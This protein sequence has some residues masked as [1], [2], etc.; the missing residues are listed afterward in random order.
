MLISYIQSGLIEQNARL[1]RLTEV[2]QYNEH[3]LLRAA[4][5]S[6]E[7]DRISEAI[8]LFNLAGDYPTVVSCL[9]IALGNIL[10]NSGPDEKAHSI[11]RTAKEILHHYERTNKVVGRNY[12]AASNL[13][14]IREAME[15]KEN[16]DLEIALGLLE[17]TNLV[18]LAEDTM[19]IAKKVEE[20]KDLHES[21]QRNLPVYL[22]LTMRTL[23]E[24]YH[25]VKNS[26]V[27]DATKQKVCISWFFDRRKC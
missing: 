25:K 7:N 16:G 18:P 3:I 5:R 12:D 19:K 20:F 4:R 10:A 17:N 24:V 8:K 2:Q 27:A 14:R 26:T 21:V 15:A 6:E 23:A 22:L 13:L 9:A 1:L 11:Q